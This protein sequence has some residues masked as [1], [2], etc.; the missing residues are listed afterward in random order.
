[1]PGEGLGGDFYFGKFF[2]DPD[3]V[4]PWIDLPAATAFDEGV[5]DG[6]GL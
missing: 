3:E 4:F 6:V 2:E 5:P 1:M